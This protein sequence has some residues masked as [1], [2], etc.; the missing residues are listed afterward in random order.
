MGASLRGMLSVDKRIILLSILVGM[1]DGH[2]NVFT[3]EVNDGIE[4]LLGHVLIEEILQS[5]LGS[6]LLV[7]KDDGQPYIEE[8]IVLQQRLNMFIAVMIL[9]K[10]FRIGCKSYFCT[11]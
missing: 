9:T 1:G 6:E 5:V 2:L 3:K 11:V 10:Y 7:V 4:L 8:H